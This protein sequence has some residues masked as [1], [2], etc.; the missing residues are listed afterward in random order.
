[1]NEWK[2]ANKSTHTDLYVIDIDTI[3]DIS[4]S[5]YLFCSVFVS[6]WLFSVELGKEVGTE[7]FL[8]PLLLQTYTFMFLFHF[9]PQNHVW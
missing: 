5:S 2:E 4:E 3:V 7:V 6:W 1:M 9:N 8:Y